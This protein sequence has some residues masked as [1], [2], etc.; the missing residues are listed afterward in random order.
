M[1]SPKNNIENN[2][3][4][5]AISSINSKVPGVDSKISNGQV[6]EAKSPS[7]KDHEKKKE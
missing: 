1:K 7:S 3:E 2:K 4:P 6:S 5:K